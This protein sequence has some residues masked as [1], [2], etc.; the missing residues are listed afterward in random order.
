MD[1]R[2]LQLLEYPKVLQHLSHFAVSEA[3]RDACLSL[4]PETDPARIAERSALVREIL[5]FCSGRDV[6]LS[7]FPDVAGVFSFLRNPLAFLDVDGLI[8]LWEMLKSAATLL[9]RLG[10]PDSVR[11]PGLTALV[12]G[13]TL[14]PKTWSGLSRCLAP[15]GTIRDEASPELYSVRQEIR[16]VHQM[17]TRKVQDF[18][19]NKDLQSMLQDEFL[20]ISSDRYVLALKN[21]FKGRLKGIVHDYSQTGETCYFEPLFLVELNNDLQE[22]K[23]G[24]RAEE[25]KVLRFLSELVRAEQGAIERTFDE[26]V[27]FDGLLAI[28]HFARRA[29]AHVIDI[30]PDAPLNVTR[31][32]HPLLV[33][34][35]DQVVPVDLVLHQGQRALIITGGNAGGKTVCLKTL[36]LL[37]LMAHAGLPVPA[38]EGSTMPLWNNFVVSMGDEQSIEQSL[39]TFT[40]QIRHFSE[41]WPRIDERTL[42]ILDEF[43]VGTDPSQGAALAQAVVDG[44]LERR[45]WVGAATHFPALKA[46]G[47]SRDGVRA[48]SVIFSPDTKKPLFKLGYDQV[49]ASRALDVAR[50]QGLPESI[51]SR[52]QEYLYL[53]AGDAEEVFERLN[54]LA[55]SKEEELDRIKARTRELELKYSRKLE[56]LD[57]ERARMRKELQAASQ[58]IMREWREGR[59]GRKEAMREIAQLR[60][61]VARSPEKEEKSDKLSIQAIA[62][63]QVLLYLPWNKTGLVQE[64]DGKKERVRLDMGGVSLWVGLED[65]Q[66][67]VRPKSDGGKVVLKSAP[68]PVAPLRLDLRGLRAD[69]AESELSRFLDKAMLAGRSEVEI[70]HGMGTGAM[71]RTVH[72]HLKRSRAVGEFRL[73]NADEGGDGVTKV[74]LAE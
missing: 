10:D 32:R 23:Q 15:D 3:G 54:L 33:F 41:V 11:Y 8:G 1:S 40:A 9:E 39:S 48:A 65:V 43:G 12:E 53:D 45:A 25:Q 68:A 20:T 72:E 49:G 31:A 42:V 63:G 60:D 14:P 52:A 5:H 55:A 16:R 2:T 37:G 4:L 38:A 58:E 28:N 70:V 44:L 46:Y 59:R 21:N 30:A 62:Q 29:D 66:T 61:S 56:K 26:L 51:L 13:L 7:A 36:G 57:Q 19:Q 69:E 34:A 64:I 6:R 22:Y 24:E 27:R 73:G 47:L 67:G 71:R 35:Q 17:C 18:F 50:E 74:V